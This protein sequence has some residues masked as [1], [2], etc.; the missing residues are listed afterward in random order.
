LYRIPIEKA[1]KTSALSLPLKG[2]EVFLRPLRVM[3]DGRRA[4]VMR[5]GY[6]KK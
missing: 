5:I 1:G 4:E 6:G 3:G 2:R